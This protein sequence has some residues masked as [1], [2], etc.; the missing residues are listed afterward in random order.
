M[1][2]KSLKR[3]EGIDDEH[4]EIR[5]TTEEDRKN[6]MPLVD[7]S[8]YRRTREGTYAEKHPVLGTAGYVASGMGSAVEGA[9]NTIEQLVT[10]KKVP[11]SYFRRE[12]EKRGYQ[13]GVT[14]AAQNAFGGKEDGITTKGEQVTGFLTDV[15]LSTVNSAANIEIGRAHV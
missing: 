3:R 2:L 15:G 12:Y 6:V 10:G 4:L 1:D 7:E 5:N 8:A 14:R 9:A 13:K 11:N